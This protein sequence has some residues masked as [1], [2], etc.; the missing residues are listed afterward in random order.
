M[1]AY[2]TLLSVAAIV[3]SANAENLIVAMFN[4]I[5]SNLD[6]Y[7]SL[8]STQSS[9]IA[10]FIPLYAEAQTY[11]D[12][13]YTTLV[14][15]ALYESISEFVT[16]LPW[17][18]S[19]I[20]PELAESGASQTASA[21]G[22]ASSSASGSAS[23]SVSASSSVASTSGSESASS[24]KSSGSSTA[25]K[26][27]SSSAAKSSSEASSESSAASSSESSAASSSESE[28]SSSA[29]STS[30]AAAVAIVPQAGSGSYAL[31]AGLVGLI[32]GVALL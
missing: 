4:D 19:R 24:S 3:A 16:A 17:Y 29:S 30:S 22:S 1:L 12:D 23:G 21:S 31:A 26:S 14:N 10:Q 11:T 5:H 27:G 8:A 32:S 6:Q 25:S 2:P 13:S 15:S 7:A 9:A 20:E 18:S 28:S